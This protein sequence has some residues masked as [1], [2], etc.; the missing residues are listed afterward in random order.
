M[1]SLGVTENEMRNGLTSADAQALSD[2]LYAWFQGIGFNFETMTLLSSLDKMSNN[3]SE[4]II[5]FRDRKAE[6]RARRRSFISADSPAIL[7]FEQ[8]TL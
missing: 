4:E 5:Y 8:H 6:R 2:R 7:P 3:S 1:S